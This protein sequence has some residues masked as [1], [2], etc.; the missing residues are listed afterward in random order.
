MFDQPDESNKIAGT[1]WS[2]LRDLLMAVATSR[3][4]FWR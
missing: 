4:H 2:E 3:L 1:G